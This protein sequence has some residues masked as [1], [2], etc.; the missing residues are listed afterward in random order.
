[1]TKFD[2]PT[3]NSNSNGEAL[4]KADVRVVVLNGSRVVM[5]Y[6]GRRWWNVQVTPVF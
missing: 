5:K 6:D 2:K 4:H 3:T 1:M